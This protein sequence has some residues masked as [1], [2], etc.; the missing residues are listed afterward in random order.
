[1]CDVNSRQTTLGLM[2]LPCVLGPV[3]HCFPVSAGSIVD[4][5]PESRGELSL[6]PRDG[7]EGGDRD[8]PVSNLSGPSGGPSCERVGATS[9]GR[10][11]QQRDVPTPNSPQG[12]CDPW[13]LPRHEG[14]ESWEEV[15]YSVT[16][17]PPKDLKGNYNTTITILLF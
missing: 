2:T 14:R 5:G 7:V 10:V 1:M 12:P 13:S 16:Q 3:T 11:P 17:Y 6:T 15:V 4:G 8:G 9:C